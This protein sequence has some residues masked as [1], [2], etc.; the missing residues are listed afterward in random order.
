VRELKN[1]LT[2][3]DRLLFVGV[4][5]VLKS[6]DGVGV[7][8]SRQIVNRPNIFAITVEVSIE[9]YIGKI[10]SMQPGEIVILDCMDLGASPGSCRLLAI[11]EVEDLTFNTHN[12]S[13]GRLRDFFPYPAYVLGIQPQT[14]AFG[15]EL[16]APVQKRA[17]MI[18]RQI[19]APLSQDLL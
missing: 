19:N 10:N 2:R 16:S 14:V 11:E 17:D 6:D 5:N 8:I 3:A 15:D 9:N 13:L 1:L 7:K 4:G 18:I 12:I